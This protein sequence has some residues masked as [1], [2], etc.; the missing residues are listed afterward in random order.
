M[1]FVL[2]V[3]GNGGGSLGEVVNMAG[4]F[5]GQKNILQVSNGKE[6]EALRSSVPQVYWGPL[7]VLVDRNSASASE[8]LAMAIQDY[9][10]GY[11]HG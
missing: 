5:I 3:A 10:R 9:G 1:V 7:M 4:M 11:H 6:S 8:I 2:K